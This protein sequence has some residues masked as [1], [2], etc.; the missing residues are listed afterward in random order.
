MSR[1]DDLEHLIR[2]SYDLIRQYEEIV[3]TSDRPKEKARARRDI[4][5]QWGLVK[6]YLA[7]YQTLCGQLG[8]PLAEDIVGQ[9]C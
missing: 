3:Q 7:E 5:E 8:R 6:G 2:D 9:G 4:E 1:K